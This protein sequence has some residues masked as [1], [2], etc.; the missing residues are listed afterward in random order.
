MSSGGSI[1]A[2][3]A[4]DTD[5]VLC[6]LLTTERLSSYLRSTN[7]DLAQAMRLYEWNIAA[8]TAVLATTGM[9]E[10]LVRNALDAQ[11]VAWAQA[12][13]EQSWLDT[14]PLDQRGVDDVAKA[15]DRATNRGRD[16]ELHGKVIAELSF[17]FWRYL[18]SQRY[19][20]S[21]WVPVLHRAFPSGGSDIRK[22]RREVEPRLVRL[23]LVR[24][25]AAHHEPIHRRDLLADL[26]TALE[27]VD[28]VHPVAGAWV[29]AQ[30]TLEQVVASRPR[31]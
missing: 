30:S 22:R 7:R 17:G 19:H 27:V 18:V 23:T 13:G 15:R 20:A 1:G 2:G 12:R 5:E 6:G 11:L 9:V 4:G 25:R 21:L 26:R 14:A 31:P 24:N 10:I 28:W 8:S 3:V 16:P 29:A